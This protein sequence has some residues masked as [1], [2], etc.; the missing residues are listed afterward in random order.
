MEDVGI[1]YGHFIYFMDKWYI[2]WPNGIFY[3]HLVH[4]VVIWPIFPVLVCCTE[5]IWQ[6]WFTYKFK[7]SYVS[8][9]VHRLS[10]PANEFKF[11]GK[12]DMILQH[13]LKLVYVFASMIVFNL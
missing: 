6:P 11:V 12:F 9:F 3:G 5:K 13:L 8:I 10:R 4:F 1:I 7:I 2:L